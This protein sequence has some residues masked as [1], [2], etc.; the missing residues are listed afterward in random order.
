[1]I[2]RSMA[3]APNGIW[4]VLRLAGL[5]ACVALA[6]SR[7][8][9][10]AHELVGHGGTAVALGA[11]VTDVKLFWFAGGWIRYQTATASIAGQLAIAMGGIA[12]ELAC[13]SVIFALARGDGL[14]RRIVRGIG[15]ALVVHASWYLATGA[16]HG[17]GDGVLLY[18]ELGSA[19]Y[20][21]AIAAGLVTCTA[22]FLGAR[23]VLGALAATLPRARVV[24][25]VIAIVLASGLHAGLAI[26]EL[27]VRSD[28]TYGQ[29]MQPEKARLVERDLAR[30]AEYER[31]HGRDVSSEERR[32]EQERLQREHRTFPFA[33]LLGIVAALAGL[34]GARRSRADGIDHIETRLLVRAAVAAAVATGIVIAIDLAL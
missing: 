11:K 16:W 24:G 17:Y 13:G 31:L 10:I 27:H 32:A 6:T 23:T 20:P 1:M 2:A 26:A 34:A 30:W 5:L 12:V 4:R 22:A 33:W 15:A 8:G 29:I 19:R 18:R 25:T 21:V 14:G 28:A 9:L 7:A 3:Q